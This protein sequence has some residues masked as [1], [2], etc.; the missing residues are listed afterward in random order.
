MNLDDL[1][2]FA[3]VPRS[4]I[5]GTLQMAAYHLPLTEAGEAT[6]GEVLAL[7]RSDLGSALPMSDE[8]WAALLADS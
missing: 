4:V 1:V 8:A 2:L 7:R 6:A 5:S 3:A